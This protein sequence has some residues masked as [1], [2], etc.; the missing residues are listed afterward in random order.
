MIETDTL[1][2]LID[3]A[4]HIPVPRPRPRVIDLAVPS[5]R[6]EIV[7]P[8]ATMTMLEDYELYVS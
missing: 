2:D 1:S 8:E 4:K 7:I 5:P 6:T 3:D